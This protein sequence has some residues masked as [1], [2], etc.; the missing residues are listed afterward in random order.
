M[1]EAAHSPACCGSSVVEHI[2]GNDE[3]G[4]SILPRSTIFLYYFI[5]FITYFQFHPFAIHPCI[6]LFLLARSLFQ[7]LHLTPLLLV[8]IQVPEP[9]FSSF[10]LEYRLSLD[11]SNWALFRDLCG[12]VLTDGQ[13]RPSRRGS[14]ADLPA[15]NP[16]TLRCRRP[17][18]FMISS[19]V[20]PPA[21]DSMVR[22]CSCLAVF[23][24]TEAISGAMGLRPAVV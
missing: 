21:C 8:R 15:K 20:V 7:H 19:I 11:R 18:A 23:G 17:V 12:F 14:S 5:D 4:S 16:R 6:H 24:M 1:A 10:R 2:I 3:V 13:L 9:A 22:T